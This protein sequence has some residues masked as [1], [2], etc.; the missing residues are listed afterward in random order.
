MRHCV[1]VC[2][3][4]AAWSSVTPFIHIFS[5]GSSALDAS[6][7]WLL[8]AQTHNARLKQA[9]LKC[10]RCA[11]HWKLCCRAGGSSTE[12]HSC[13]NSMETAPTEPVAEDNAA[14]HLEDLKLDDDTNNW[15]EELPTGLSVG[16][17]AQYAWKQLLK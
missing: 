4:E 3:C 5:A 10:T 15:G 11:E 1:C 7:D 6:W 9:L 13:S 17:I 12:E 14:L 8:F 16:S 2:V